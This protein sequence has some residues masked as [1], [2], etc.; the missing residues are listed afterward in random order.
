MGES[1]PMFADPSPPV[2]RRRTSESAICELGRAR[3]EPSRWRRAEDRRPLK[4]GHAT[5]PRPAAKGDSIRDFAGERT[6]AKL[7]LCEP[8][9]PRN[10]RRETQQAGRPSRPLRVSTDLTLQ[11]AQ[12]PEH[13]PRQSQVYASHRP[14]AETARCLSA[15]SAA[16]CQRKLP[17][18][19]GF[20]REPQGLRDVLSL[21]IRVK[22]QYLVDRHTLGD[23]VHYDGNGNAEP[24]DTRGATHLVG[25]RRDAREGHPESLAFPSL[26][27]Q[28]SGVCGH[29][30]AWCQ[31]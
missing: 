9:R 5:A 8:T 30:N 18:P 14:N 20:R 22:L 23:H 21:Q 11:R 16:G 31:T 29:G 15:A 24:A 27:T 1:T 28:R 3:L 13:G 7:S 19:N 12:V 4:L 2:C 17:L 26:P 25:A 10:P 6:T